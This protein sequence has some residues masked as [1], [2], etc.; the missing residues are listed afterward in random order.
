MK[1]MTAQLTQQMKKRAEKAL[2]R[3][4]NQTS[5]NWLYQPQAPAALK[6]FAKHKD[7]R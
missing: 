5:C 6:D 1:S 4:A 3:D 2:R 7:V